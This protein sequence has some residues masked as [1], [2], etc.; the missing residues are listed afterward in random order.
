MENKQKNNWRGL[1]LGGKVSVQITNEVIDFDQETADWVQRY[2]ETMAE[3]KAL[4]EQADIARS[5]IESAMGDCQIG[6]YHNRPLVRWTTVTTTRL[7]TTKVKA[8][9]SP[10]LIE[11]FS[12]TS[13]AR[14][15]TLLDEDSQ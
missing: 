5:Y 11:Q 10:E 1:V 8:A 7:D 15:F 9:L 2:R 3:I 12:N 6:F 4:Q 14:R 13:T